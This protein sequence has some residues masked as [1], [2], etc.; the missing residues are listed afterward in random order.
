MV[1]WKVKKGQL[2]VNGVKAVAETYDRARDLI[3]T[4]VEDMTFSVRN[5]SMLDHLGI[6]YTARFLAA[7]YH[8]KTK[9]KVLG[10][11]IRRIE[12]ELGF[13]KPLRFAG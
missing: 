7:R 6:L 12:K 1:L 9:E 2:V 5:F 10:A 3:Y 13:Q 8:Y 4:S 11:N